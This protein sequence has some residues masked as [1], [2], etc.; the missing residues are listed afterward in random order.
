M[1]AATSQATVCG[2]MLWLAV[3]AGALVG[4]P[5]LRVDKRASV[6]M[7][8]D[9]HEAAD[10]PTSLQKQVEVGSA[11]EEVRKELGREEEEARREEERRAGEAQADAQSLNTKLDALWG[12]PPGI[13]DVG[14]GMSTGSLSYLD[15]RDSYVGEVDSSELLAMDEEKGFWPVENLPVGDRDTDETMLWVDE[16]SVRTSHHTSHLSRAA[17]AWPSAPAL[18][19]AHTRALDSRAQCIGCKWCSDVARSTFQMTEPY[20]VA[21]VVQQGGDSEDV[22]EEAID[23]CPNDCI[24]FC[25]RSELEVLEEHRSLGYIDDLLASY[26]LGGR[27]TSEGEGGKGMAVPHWKDPIVNQGWRKGDKYVRTRR[28]RMVDPLLRKSGERG[29]A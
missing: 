25:T 26:H 18:P 19:P 22:V 8:D 2:L 10:P 9:A 14:E 3:A 17:L 16:L 20:G 23:C 27:L 24:H 1:A 15:E 13:G 21:Q 29:I 7:S 6:F 28:N 5:P 4:G 11:A 12:V